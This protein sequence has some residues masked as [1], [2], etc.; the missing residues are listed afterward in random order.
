MEKSEVSNLAASVENSAAG[1]QGVLGT[2]TIELRIS[3]PGR[4]DTKALESRAR[5]Q[6]TDSSVPKWGPSEHS[7]NQF[8]TRLQ[9]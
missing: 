9:K 4:K 8:Q 1:R 7:L 2:V 5:F 3:T 6:V